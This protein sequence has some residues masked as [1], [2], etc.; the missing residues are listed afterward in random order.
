MADREFHISISSGTVVKTLVILALAALVY[1][2][3][4]L[5]LIVL[6]A[7]TI[8]SALEPGVTALVR[9]GLPRILAVIAVYLVL[10]G[11]FFVLFYSFFPSVL[12]DFA[13]FAA[14]LPSYLES[15]AHTGAF[16]SYAAILGLPSPSS[17]SAADIMNGIREGLDAGS[18]FGNPVSAVTHIFGGVFSF[19]LIFVF[20]FYFAV[21]ETGVDGF[22]RVVTPKSHQQYILGL[23]RRSQRKIGLWMQ[24]QLILAVIMGV[25]VFLGLTILGIP[26]ALVLAVIA[27]CFEIIPVFGPT[28]SAIPAVVIG[29]VNGGPLI[30]LVVI[31]LYIIFQ[32]FE[33]HLIYPLVVTRVVGVPP[34][35]V[36]L[37]LIVGGELF[38]FPGIIL[39]VPAAATL[40][41]FVRD[42]E[43]GRLPKREQEAIL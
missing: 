11:V 38:G 30:G 18:V 1:K 19:L 9:R 36:I 33:N 42:I 10:F 2:I 23:W 29:F 32:Q 24:G 15:F 37:A 40:Q 43:E 22:L 34:L 35:L 27:G 25:L 5:I 7:I 28:L 20:S 6:V 4:D 12:E 41:E 14:Q 39:S 13:T 16:D 17:I 8:A 31:G 3:R 26:H 21:I